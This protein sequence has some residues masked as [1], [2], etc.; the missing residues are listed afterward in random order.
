[1]P[2]TIVL[3]RASGSG[4]LIAAIDRDLGGETEI[5]MFECACH[6]DADGE[7]AVGVCHARDG[8]A[9][10]PPVW[11]PYFAVVKGWLGGAAA[12]IQRAEAFTLVSQ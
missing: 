2:N 10:L 8:N 7:V 6:L 5:V 12:H 3:R 1:M 4:P 9:G 11:L